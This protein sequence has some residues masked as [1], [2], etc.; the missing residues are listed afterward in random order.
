MS[1]SLGSLMYTIISRVIL[2]IIILIIALPLSLCFLFGGT[3][4]VDNK[5]FLLVQRFFD[6]ACVRL[7][8]IPI[9]YIG[10]E[11]LPPE[12]CIVVANHQSSFDIPLVGYILRKR[13]HI[14]IAWAELT[15]GPL[16]RFLLPR[17]A[18]LV[19]VSS[20]TRAVRTLV[21]AINIV[22]AHPWDLVI[23]PEG[24]RHTDGKV[25][26]FFGGFALIAKKI[27]RSVVPVKIIGVNKVYPP[28][29]FWMH[30]HPITVIIGPTMMIG[31]EETEHEFKDRVYAWFVNTQG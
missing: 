23:F 26:E 7:A 4:I 27:N 25:H 19:D 8:L 18:V 20:P 13:P 22:K 12:P 21:K 29:T 31:A 9:T 28:K 16:L 10:L 1:V 2:T 15:K 24:A 17:I 11:N 14:W 30:R 3:Y 5:L 6:W